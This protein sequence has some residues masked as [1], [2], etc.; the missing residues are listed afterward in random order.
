MSRRYSLSG[1]CGAAVMRGG[2]RCKQAEKGSAVV[3]RACAAENIPM[4]RLM[5]SRLLTRV[6]RQRHSAWLGRGRELGRGLGVR[7]RH[8]RTSDS[9]LSAWYARQ[10]QRSASTGLIEAPAPSAAAP[11]PCAAAVACGGAAA[12]EY[13]DIVL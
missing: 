5:A 11:T 9:V 4:V 3:A 12:G 13:R 10:T 7:G 8:S 1:S 6:G 2:G